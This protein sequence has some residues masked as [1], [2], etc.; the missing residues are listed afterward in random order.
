MYIYVFS[1]KEDFL[2]EIVKI[3]V[4]MCKWLLLAV[5]LGEVLPRM[6]KYMNNIHGNTIQ[7]D[8]STGIH[9]LELLG[10]T[11]GVTSSLLVGAMMLLCSAYFCYKIGMAKMLKC[12]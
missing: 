8:K 6:S 10:M 7:V 9:V 1:G 3:I 11:A 12:C 5:I 2:C 4:K